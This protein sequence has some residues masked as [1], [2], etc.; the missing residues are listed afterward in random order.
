[1][2]A[3]AKSALEQE[4]GRY[5]WFHT[6]DFGG[7]VVAR[8]HC[9]APIL[10]AKADCYFSASPK[11]KSVLDIGCWDGYFSLEALRRGAA[12]VLSTDHYVWHAQWSRGSFELVRDRLAPEL[13][14]KDIDV[15]DIS[16]EAVGR[17]DIVLFAGLFYH[18]RH[19][20]LALERAASVCNELLVLETVL[21]AAKLGRPGMV[22]YPGDELKGDA[23]NW[24]GPNRLCVEAMLRDVGFKAISFTPTPIP[25]Q[26]TIF[27]W[28][29]RNP[30]ITPRGVFH[31]RRGG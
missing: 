13:E 30:A 29:R 6:I 7:G 21:D 23:S 17:F 22:F 2:D 16:P 24:W 15:Y 18:L 11:G 14:V 26:W 10:Q 3:K 4:I 31:A 1:M 12:R 9:T 5:D 27:D 25:R 19:P 8:G 28:V 20:L